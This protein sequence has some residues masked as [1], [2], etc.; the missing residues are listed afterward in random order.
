MPFIAVLDIFGFEVFDLNS[1]EQLLINFANERLH[2]VFVQTIFRAEQEDYEK[3]GIDWSSVDFEDNADCVQLID[4]RGGTEKD[5]FFVF[6]FS[7]F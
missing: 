3:E 2:Q 6:L 4:G 5:C 7:F 1:L